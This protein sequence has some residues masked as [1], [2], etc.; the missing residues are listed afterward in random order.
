MVGKAFFSPLLGDNECF[1]W[2]GF[3]I[4]R[5]WKPAT[6]PT[7]SVAMKWVFV[8]YHKPAPIRF[9]LGVHRILSRDRCCGIPA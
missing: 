7:A 5:S 1:N 2:V 4:V 9:S 8:N 3:G 6:A